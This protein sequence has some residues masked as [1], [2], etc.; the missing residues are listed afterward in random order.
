MEQPAEWNP[1]RDPAQRDHDEPE[2]NAPNQEGEQQN[3]RQKQWNRKKLEKN[4]ICEAPLNITQRTGVMSRAQ[5]PE[6][7]RKAES[8]ENKETGKKTPQAT[9][10]TRKKR[11]TVDRPWNRPY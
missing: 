8:K 2:T 11:E 7:G 4:K 6:A 10:P 3:C 5:Q 1:R 9:R